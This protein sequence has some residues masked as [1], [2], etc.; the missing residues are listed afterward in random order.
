M[1]YAVSATKIQQNSIKYLIFVILIVIAGLVV[2]FRLQP[3]QE[4]SDA[5]VSSSQTTPANQTALAPQTSEEGPV[6]IEVT[7]TDLSV[8]STIWKFKLALDTHSEELNQDL[9][10]V[11]TMADDQDNS[12]QPIAWEGSPPEGHHREGELFFNAISPRPNSLSI[13]VKNIGGIVERTFRWDL[14]GGE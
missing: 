10:K 3:R 8:S 5:S 6:T 14:K 7:P 12:F 2:F 4:N 11:I 13:I 9:T 1:L